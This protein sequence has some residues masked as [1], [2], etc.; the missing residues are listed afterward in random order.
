MFPIRQQLVFP[1]VELADEDG[2]L[3][4]GGDLSI[5]RL[6]LAYKSGIFPWYSEGEPILWYSPDPRFVLYPEEL[7]IHK[8]MKKVLRSTQFTFTINHAFDQVI[9]SCKEIN[10]IDQDGTWITDS[11]EEAYIQLH[12]NGLALSGECWFGG[13]LVGGCYG[14]LTGKVFCGESMFSSMSNASKFAFIHLVQHLVESGI[15]LIDCQIERAHLKSLGA[16]FISRS[17]YIEYLKT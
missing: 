9:R 4:F 10:R 2:L 16:R 15:A 17:L 6:Q 7:I 1:P 12:K 13:K 14:V 11:M 3:A 8:S 5:S